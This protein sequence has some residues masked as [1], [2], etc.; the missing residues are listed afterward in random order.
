M[1]CNPQDL[2]NQAYNKGFIMN[3]SEMLRKLADIIDRMQNDAGA[4]PQQGNPASQGEP[5]QM[6]PAANLTVVNVDHEDTSDTTTMVNPLQQKLELLKKAV[7]V[8]NMYDQSSDCDTCEP[9][10]Q[11]EPAAESEDEIDIMRRNAGI[12]SP[13]TAVIASET[14]ETNPS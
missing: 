12:G 1:V 7:G 2:G 6:Q 10:A 3:T 13:E 4:A 5:Q 9:E 14:D 11:V 8:D